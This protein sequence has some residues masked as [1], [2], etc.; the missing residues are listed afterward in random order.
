MKTTT[1]DKFASICAILAGLAG[2][3][4][5]A[6]FFVLKNPAALAPALSLLLVGLLSSAALVA[7]YQHVRQVEAG[8]ALWGF[9]L[10]IG[11]AAGAA[12]H[13]AFDIANN[14]QPP[15]TPFDYASP[16][17]PRGFL[18]FAVAGLAAIILGWLIVRGEVFTRAL[19]YFGVLSGIL[20]VALYV[21]YM[22]ILN[23][24]NPIVLVLVVLSGLAQPIWY[25]WLGVALRRSA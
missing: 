9:L 6:F 17:D 20:L 16:I 5:L 24:L 12:I 25:I 13:A 14:F 15:A 19:G 11:G 22:I 10:G 8:F 23:A 1:F 4:Y 2:F 7:V 18:T 21:A 3:A